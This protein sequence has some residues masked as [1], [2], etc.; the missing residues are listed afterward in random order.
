M[1]YR[2]E[3]KEAFNIVGIMPAAAV[4]SRNSGICSRISSTGLICSP[5]KTIAFCNY[6]TFSR[7]VN[8]AFRHSQ[9]SFSKKPKDCPEQS[10]WCNPAT[11]SFKENRRRFYDQTGW[12]RTLGAPAY[13]TEWRTA[14]QAN[15]GFHWA[16]FLFFPGRY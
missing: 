12:P 13:S 2:I 15:R 7:M 11:Q 8:N 1:N 9:N 14:S 16:S 4:V 10:K 5:P 3:E 6:N